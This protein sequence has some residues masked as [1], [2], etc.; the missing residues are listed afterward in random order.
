MVEK[1]DDM[2]SRT[3]STTTHVLRLETTPDLTNF[4]RVSL[5]AAHF[6][7]ECALALTARARHP[8]AAA[9]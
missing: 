8:A 7:G 2:M 6:T 1:E 9:L 3:H 4:G 5:E